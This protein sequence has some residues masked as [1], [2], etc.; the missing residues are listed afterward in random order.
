MFH[1]NSNKIRSLQASFTSFD[2][3]KP[4]SQDKRIHSKVRL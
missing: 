4:V 3:L 1:C 2:Y